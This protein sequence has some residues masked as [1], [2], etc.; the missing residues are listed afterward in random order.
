[1]KKTILT[2]LI[3]L[4]LLGCNH[5]EKLAPSAPITGELNADI[6]ALLPAGKYEARVQGIKHSLRLN[7]LQQRFR[8][9]INTNYQWFQEYINSNSRLKP[10]EAVPYHENLG[11]SESEYDEMIKLLNEIRYETVDTESIEIRRNENE[12]V[13]S[14]SGELKVYG[15]IVIHVD[16]NYVSIG[17]IPCLEF[18]LLEIEDPENGFGSSWNGYQWK[19]ET[20][21][22]L[23]DISNLTGRQIKFTLGRLND[24]GERYLGF[25]VREFKGGEQIANTKTTVLM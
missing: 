16:S 13:L 18:E 5:G 14:G 7:D 19:D 6:N 23:D 2:S 8:K 17:E 9:A 11:L 15:D 25:Q 20:V 3:A 12:V 21:D 1:M 4:L 10:G 24:S 22:S